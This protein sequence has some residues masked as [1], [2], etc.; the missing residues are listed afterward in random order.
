MAG[1]MSGSFG[2]WCPWCMNSCA[3]CGKDISKP[4]YIWSNFGRGEP[5]ADNGKLCVS[6]GMKRRS[7]ENI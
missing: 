4:Q 6:C 3:E 7:D 1:T 2:H 5:V